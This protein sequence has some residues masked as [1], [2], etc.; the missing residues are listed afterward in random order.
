MTTQITSDRYFRLYP[1]I[2]ITLE[3]HCYQIRVFTLDRT[4]I[5][6][7]TYFRIS[8]FVI[9]HLEKSYTICVI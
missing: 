5:Q 4:Q 2:C 7:F 6:L 1:N 8:Q 3:F 9:S